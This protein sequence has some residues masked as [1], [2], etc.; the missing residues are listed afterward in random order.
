M[1]T[2]RMVSS[3]ISNLPH[4]L[5]DGHRPGTVLSAGAHTASDAAFVTS[6]PCK[7][8][9]LQP[10][11]FARAQAAVALDTEQDLGPVVVDGIPRV[12]TAEPY[13][14]ETYQWQGNGIHYAVA[15]EGKP[16]L[17]VHGFGA[18]VGHWRKNIPLLAQTHKVYALDLLGFGQSDKPLIAYS[19]EMWKQLVLDFMHDVID[20]PAV[21]VGNSLGS[22]IC[23][24]ACTERPDSIAGLIMLNCAGGMNNKAISDDWRIKLATPVFLLIDVLLSRQRIARYLFD[25]FRS[26]ENLRKVLGRVYRNPAAVDDAL[27]D[28]IYTPSSMDGALEAFVSIIT[29]PAGPRPE[30]HLPNVACPVGILWGSNDP[31]TPLDGPVGKYFKQ[32]PS[33]QSNI[34]FLELP[35]VGHCPH[36]DRPE[37]V[38]AE[39]QAFLAQHH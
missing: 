36:D 16:V 29:G 23:L 33:K 5:R 12:E 25:R 4:H 3:I 30:D 19:I 17:L 38:N 18:S 7:R 11:A 35:G 10:Q 20:G 21:L 9:R 28:L 31:F 26:R 27:I 6:T 39:I 14:T 13:L 34:S 37:L 1:N 2:P 8:R 15:G 22:L 32:L 24:V